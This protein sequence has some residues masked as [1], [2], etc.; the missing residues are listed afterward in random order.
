MAK[1]SVLHRIKHFR[2]IKLLRLLGVA[3][4]ISTLANQQSLAANLYETKAKVVLKD[5]QVRQTNNAE[6]VEFFLSAP[7]Q[8]KRKFSLDNPNRLVIDFSTLQAKIGLPSKYKGNLIKKIRFGTNDA[9]TSRAVIELNTPL[10]YINLQHFPAQG[11]QPYKIIVEMRANTKLGPQFNETKPSKAKTPTLAYKTPTPLTTNLPLKPVNSPNNLPSNHKPTIVID[12]G[13]G[14]KDPGTQGKNGTL[15]KNITLIYAKK[16]RDQLLRTGRY[17][18]KL[19][20]ADDRFILLHE[21]VNIARQAKADLFI[22][23]H[24][25]SAPSEKA[26]GLSLYT[27]SEIASDKEAESL[28]ERENK[29]DIISGMDLSV[30]DEKVAGI[31]IELAQRETKN[32]SSSFAEKLSNTIRQ[33]SVRQLPGAHRFAGFRVLKAPDIPSVLVE[34]GFLSN[35]E[36]EKLINS[37][38]Y[39]EKIA[40]GVSTGIDKF[41]A[42]KRQSQPNNMA[43]K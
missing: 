22:S 4:L 36:E 30:Q 17:N 40:Q 18:V 9:T 35:T 25:D 31:L 23:I 29:S 12:A 13:H 43:E 38:E 14:G 1:P 11:K 42:Q 3:V 33:Q 28:A 27:V 19:T 20:R 21:R 37:A 32:K 2:P 34:I 10:S 26:R 41:F 16:I 5:I 7:V 24:A 8:T 6:F 39:R 15:E